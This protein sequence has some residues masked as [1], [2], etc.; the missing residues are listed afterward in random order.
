MAGDFIFI[1]GEFCL[2]PFLLGCVFGV[3]QSVL[4]FRRD[5]LMARRWPEMTGL[6]AVAGIGIL[7][8]FLFIL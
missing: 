5:R 8:L 4:F 7:L 6:G 1:L 2:A 3:I